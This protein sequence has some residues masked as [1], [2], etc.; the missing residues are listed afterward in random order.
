MRGCCVQRCR[1]VVLCTAA[2][3]TLH[4]ATEKQPLCA[5]LSRHPTCGL[6]T[7]VYPATAVSAPRFRRRVYLTLPCACRAPRR[8]APRL[9]PQ[10]PRGPRF[11]RPPRRKPLPSLPAAH[12]PVTEIHR[13]HGNQHARVPPRPATIPPAAPRPSLHPQLHLRRHTA[14]AGL[15]SRL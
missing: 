1:R 8:G 5:T 11:H 10:R 14:A 12:V 4:N 15:L 2:V 3:A 9:G 7:F 13:A 6:C